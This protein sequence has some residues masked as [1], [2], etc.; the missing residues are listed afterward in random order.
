MAQAA[1]VTAGGSPGR[2]MI[3]TAAKRESRIAEIRRRLHIGSGTPTV[4][5][6]KAACT[7]DFARQAEVVTWIDRPM[8]DVW[9]Y[10]D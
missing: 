6:Q 9:P 3:A 2:A 1:A 5:R 8:L 4:P 7:A 10:G